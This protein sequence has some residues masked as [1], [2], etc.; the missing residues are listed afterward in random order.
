MWTNILKKKS[1]KFSES[2][3]E[4]NN[5]I[6]RLKESIRGLMLH[7][8]QQSGDTIADLDKAVDMYVDGIMK[9]ILQGDAETIYNRFKHKRE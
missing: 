7:G 3:I 5:T 6:K 1:Y 9:D 4:I 8:W 2:Q